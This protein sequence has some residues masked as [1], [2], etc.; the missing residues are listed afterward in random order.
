[1]GPS[2]GLVSALR[3]LLAGLYCTQTVNAAC[4]KGQFECGRGFCIP[5]SWT[6]DG[7]EDCPRGEDEKSCSLESCDATQFACRNSQCIMKSWLCDGDVDCVDGSDEEH[8]PLEPCAATQFACR[9]SQCIRKSWLCDGDVDCFD[10][11]DEEHCPPSKPE[12]TDALNSQNQDTAKAGESDKP[13]ETPGI[14]NK[15]TTTVEPRNVSYILNYT[16]SGWYQPNDTIKR[17]P[18]TKIDTTQSVNNSRSNS[19][20]REDAK[21]SEKLTV[22]TSGA[23]SAQEVHFALSLVPLLRAQ[24]PRA[25]LDAEANILTYLKERQTV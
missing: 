16:A 24:P 14:I 3:C 19:E 4:P 11:S 22:A 13:T 6:C 5:E 18:T 8:C 23:S 1:M 12:T 10:G 25:R 15:N 21:E 20:D 17:T 9:N 2:R 7:Q